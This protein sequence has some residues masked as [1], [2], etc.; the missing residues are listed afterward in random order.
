MLWY[1][2]L[3]VIFEKDRVL[4]EGNEGEYCDLEEGLGGRGGFRDL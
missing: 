4:R 3:L 2:I 1:K